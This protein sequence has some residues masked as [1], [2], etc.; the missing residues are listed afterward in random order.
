[1]QCDEDALP[2]SHRIPHRQASIERSRPELNRA[3]SLCNKLAKS[4]AQ[5]SGNEVL[6]S[7][8]FPPLSAY[9]GRGGDRLGRL[10]GIHTQ[11]ERWIPA[12]VYPRAGGDGDDIKHQGT[13]LTQYALLWQ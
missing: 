2:S 3:V 13:F 7:L 11:S 6:V 8:S 5:Y 12:V 9:A 10:A 1:M 4:G